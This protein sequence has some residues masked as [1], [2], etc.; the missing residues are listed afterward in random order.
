MELWLDRARDVLSRAELHRGQRSAS[1]G[2]GD[3][4][5]AVLALDRLAG[6]EPVIAARA[7]EARALRSRTLEE[8]AGAWSEAAAAIAASARY[9]GLQVAPELGLIPLRED[10]GS[11]LWQFWLPLSG[12]APAI[13][14]ASGRIA[15]AP[16]TAVVLVLCPGGSFDRGPMWG[17]SGGSTA[18]VEP[19]FMGLHEVTRAQWRRIM[20][21]GYAP[22]AA[23]LLGRGNPELD[24]ARAEIGELNPV[25]SVHWFDA[26]LFARRLGCTLP[27]EEQWELAARA[28]EPADPAGFE[29]RENVAD[30]SAAGL[31]LAQVAPWNDGFPVHAPVGSFEPNAFGLFDVAGNVSEWCRTGW[32][33]GED[34]AAEGGRAAF[35]GG[36]WHH[37][38]EF[39][40]SSF[41]EGDNPRGLN[42]ARGLRLARELER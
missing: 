20:G 7:V 13:D 14:P 6:L 27:S 4:S 25:D 21:D 39:C 3:L 18:V 41:R 36:S 33:P 24:A 28:G 40:R 16:E 15:L 8:P 29:G 32:T 11:G 10:P 17:S 2:D 26:M 12:V 34:P 22:Y 35:R 42:Q 38:P 5:A 23:I 1:P 19:F 37:S 30:R 31:L 9:A